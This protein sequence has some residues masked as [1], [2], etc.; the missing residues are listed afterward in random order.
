WY[1]DNYAKANEFDLV[2]NCT[3]NYDSTKFYSV[4]FKQTELYLR[5]IDKS[6]FVSGRYITK[7]RSY[8]NECE[9]EFKKNPQ[10]DGPPEGLDYDFILCTQEIDE[11]LALIDKPKTIS[12]KI[13]EN[14]GTVCIDV[15]MKLKFH[16]TKEN[17][18]WLIDDIE[19]ISN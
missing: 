7:W 14:T 2:N 10:N 8:F 16:L 3:T 18:K 9:K 17:N 1:K 15:Y 11:T 6:N 5:Y 13:E 12:V 4:N 19:N